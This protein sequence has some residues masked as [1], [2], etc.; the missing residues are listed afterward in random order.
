VDN[1]GLA[2]DHRRREAALR[3]V[4][5]LKVGNIP[6]TVAADHLAGET[7]GEVI[8]RL[9]QIKPRH[10]GPNASRAGAAARGGFGSGRA[11]NLG[12]ADHRTGEACV[13]VVAR[14]SGLNST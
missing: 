1:A 9:E 6:Y 2:Q 10:T 7:C 12:S 14:Q 8:V 4:H 13:E 3:A 5:I 11:D